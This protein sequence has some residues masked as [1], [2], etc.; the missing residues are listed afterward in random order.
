MRGK[1]REKMVQRYERNQRKLRKGRDTRMEMIRRRRIK[2]SKN[3]RCRISRLG[4]MM[5]RKGRKYI[6]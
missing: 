5:R 2:Q 3:G 4:K 6:S 1:S